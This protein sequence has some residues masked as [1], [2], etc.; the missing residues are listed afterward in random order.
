VIAACGGR[1][2]GGRLWLARRGTAGVSLAASV[3][4]C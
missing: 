4:K 2:N 1:A 3:C